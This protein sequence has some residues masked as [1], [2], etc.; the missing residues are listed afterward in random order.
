MPKSASG[1]DTMTVQ[2]VRDLTGLSASKIYDAVS[3]GELPGFKVGRS[4]RVWRKKYEALR[5]GPTPLLQP[6]PNQ[7]AA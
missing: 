5:D 7:K 1:T 2:E 3:R 6:T 4:V